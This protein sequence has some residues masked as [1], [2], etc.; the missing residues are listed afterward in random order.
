MGK[1]KSD[2]DWVHI[3]ARKLTKPGRVMSTLWKLLSQKKVSPSKA[4]SLL[5]EFFS[6]TG[7]PIVVVIDELDYLI[8]RK[9]KELYT[10]VDW[11]SRPRSRLIVI[12]IANTLDLPERVL[13][14]RIAS[15]FG[16][17]GL[18]FAPYSREQLTQLI[19][20]RLEKTEVFDADA[21]A[22]CSMKISSTLGDAR[23]A[24]NLCR[25][26]FILFIVFIFV[27]IINYSYSILK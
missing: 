1:K 26:V 25:F 22:F 12:G 6:S 7:D 23:R 21:I 15:R 16:T 4:T 14:P 18:S 10:I 13:L 19:Q 24:L 8:S 5:E 17:E 9:Q 20:S 11:P 27:I 3:N 2:F